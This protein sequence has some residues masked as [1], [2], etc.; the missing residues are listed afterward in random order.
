MSR[1]DYNTSPEG[2]VLL[3]STKAPVHP[4]LPDNT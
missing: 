1:L 3:M 4:E 2:L